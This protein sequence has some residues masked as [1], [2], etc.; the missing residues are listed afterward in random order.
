MNTLRLNLLFLFISFCAYSGAQNTWHKLE[1]VGGS[2]RER[3]VS[4]SIGSKGYVGLGQDTLHPEPDA[5]G[6][7]GI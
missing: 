3:A 7:L 1:S 4:F 6:F 2:K 5:E